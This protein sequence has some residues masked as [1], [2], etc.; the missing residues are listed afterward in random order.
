MLSF[1]QHSEDGDWVE[2]R[3]DTVIAAG[4]T[5]YQ[6]YLFFRSPVHG[7]CV[8]LDGDIQ[9]CA[10]DEAIYHEALVHPAMLLHPDPRRVLIMGG[11]EGATA[12]EVLRH[13]GVGEVVMVDIDRRFVE[14]CGEHLASWN[15]EAFAD[16]RLTVLC[17]DIN[18]YLCEPG[19]GFDVVIGDLVDFS[20]PADPAAALYS[21]PLYARLRPRLEPGAVV[22]TQAGGVTTSRTAAHAHVRATLRRAF[23]GVASYG[24]VVPSFYHLWSY[25]VAS[26]G[27]L[28]AAGELPLERFS[29]RAAERGLSLPATGAVH[30]ATAFSLPAAIAD[31]LDQPGS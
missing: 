4:E 9:S 1:G 30:L 16:P 15:A 21:D 27:P 18:E 12:R 31:S 28:P 2:H 7:V 11:G 6:S 17:R 19:P 22:A 25:V 24:V 23:A 14:L 29:H 8:A 26:D 5:D 10:E 3:V 13:P 20:D